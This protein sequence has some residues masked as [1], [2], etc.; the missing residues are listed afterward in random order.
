MAGIRGSRS[1]SGITDPASKKRW[2]NDENGPKGI[3]GIR[4]GRFEALTLSFRP[5]HRG[6]NCDKLDFDCA[7]RAISRRNEVG[8][9]KT[10]QSAPVAQLDRVLPSEGRGHRFES[11]RARQKTQRVPSGALFVFRFPTVFEPGSIKRASVLDAGSPGGAKPRESA[12]ADLSQSCRARQK[13]KGSLLGPFCFS[14]PNSVRTWFD[15]HRQ[16]R[17]F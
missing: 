10:R 9:K 7:R 1:L 3:A 17:R 15:T 11:C 13:H 14:L 6:L 8:Q 2:K 5:L 12:L 4:V 16:E